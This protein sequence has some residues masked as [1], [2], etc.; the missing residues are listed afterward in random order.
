[1]LPVFQNK[2]AAAVLQQAAFLFQSKCF[3]FCNMSKARLSALPQCFCS[4][5]CKATS[6]VP[7]DLSLSRL[8]FSLIYQVFGAFESLV[9]SYL[10]D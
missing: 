4:P 6:R 7:G 8:R 3:C 2:G 1:M 5:K 10:Y 9:M